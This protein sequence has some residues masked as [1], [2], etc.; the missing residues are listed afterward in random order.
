[1]S[2]LAGQTAGKHRADDALYG[3]PRARGRARRWRLPRPKQKNAALEPWRARIEARMP[4]R[5]SKPTSN[6]IDAARGK[7]RD[8][9]FIDRL[10]LERS[11]RRGDGQGLAR[12]RR[13][14]RSGR[15]GD[16]ALDAA[17]RPGDLARARAARRDRH[18]LRVAAERDGRRRRA[19][20]QV[21]QR[22]DPARRLGELPHLARDL[23]RADR[24]LARGRPARGRDP[25]RADRRPRGGGLHAR[26]AWRRHRRDRAA[27]RQEP[28][29]AR[30][31]RGARA[32]VRASRRRLPRLRASAGRSRHGEDHRAQRQDAADRRVR[33]GRD[34]ARRSRRGADPSCAAGRDADRGRLRGEGRCRHAARR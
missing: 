25:A 9:A 22:R 14:C 2:V 28:G 29:R 23:Q 27:R 21:R 17:E 3:P 34:A 33:R 26:R 15:R 12:H 8:E 20:P 18:H 7:G 16:G 1:M 6:D 19:L 4:A 11:A 10:A 31:G 30:A 5:S 24:G 32:G 13:A